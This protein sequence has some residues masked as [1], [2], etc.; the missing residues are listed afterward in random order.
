MWGGPYTDALFHTSLGGG[1]SGVSYLG[2]IRNDHALL[3]TLVGWW[4][5]THPFHLSVGEV[6]IMLQD[7]RVLLSLLTEGRAVVSPVMNDVW[8]TY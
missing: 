6:T 2:I 7:V 8:A 5:E 1:L 4:T 3:T